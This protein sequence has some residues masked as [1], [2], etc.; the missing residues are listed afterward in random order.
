MWKLAQNQLGSGLAWSC[1][2]QANP[3][4]E[5]SD[6]IYPGE[7]LNIPASCSASGAGLQASKVSPTARASN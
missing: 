2:A 3:Q 4:I 6:R 5:N 7:I 1:I